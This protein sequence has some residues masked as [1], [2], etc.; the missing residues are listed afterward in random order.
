MESISF[1]EWYEKNGLISIT[2]D[3]EKRLLIGYNADFSDE[4]RLVL[5]KSIDSEFNLIELFESNKDKG[6]FIYQVTLSGYEDKDYL[7]CRE[8]V[9]TL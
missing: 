5:S 4:K 9:D 1:K 2:I 3:F 8:I 6:D 7:W